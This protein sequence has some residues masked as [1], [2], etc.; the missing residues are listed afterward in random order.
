MGASSPMATSEAGTGVGDDGCLRCLD[1]GLYG[2]GGLLA[3]GL[4]GDDGHRA[5]LLHRWR[6][7]GFLGGLQKVMGQWRRLS[8]RVSD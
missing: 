1:G 4:G 2:D 7:W 5:V 3:G 6:G 8:E